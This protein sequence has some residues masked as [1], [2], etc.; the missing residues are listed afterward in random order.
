MASGGHQK[1]PYRQG[2]GMMLL[3]A[4]GRVFV[5][6]RVGEAADAWQMPQGG[7]DEG[8]APRAAALRELEEEVGT[9]KARIVAEAG[10][11]LS[12]DL[13]PEVA[14]R[15]WGGKYRGQCHKWFLLRFLGTNADIDLARHRP[16]E[17]SHWRW[18][19]PGALP[20]L[21]VPFKRALYE[22]VLDELRPH[23][24]DMDE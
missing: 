10:R 14:G 17:F 9:A 24:G 15:V 23:F 21:V 20:A 5:G 2:V 11:W 12:Y 13:P 7:I 16:A 22:T 6:R 8:E 4:E 3:N 18:V 19:E 1:L